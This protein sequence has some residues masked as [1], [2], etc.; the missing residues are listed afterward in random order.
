MSDTPDWLPPLVL[1]DDYSGNWHAYLNALYAWFKQDFIDDKPVF[2]GRRLDLKRH[3]MIHN[4]EATF[5]HFIQEGPVENDRTPDFRRCER[6]R[7]PKPAI[8]HS[9]N[10]VIK[11]WRNKRGNEDR[12][13]LW[14]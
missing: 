12:V 7:W 6:I 10:P 14:F 3:P 13:C 11:V 5:W 8:N 2:I 4:K 9:G 1:L